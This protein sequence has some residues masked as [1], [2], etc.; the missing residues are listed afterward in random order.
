MKITFDSFAQSLEARFT[1][2]DNRFNQVFSD[3][4]KVDIVHS[5]DVSQDVLIVP[6]AALSIVDG[7][8]E[9]T[10]D[11][12]LLAPCSGSLRSTLGRPVEQ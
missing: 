3:A 11:R 2:V 5:S 6:L 12:S 1:S 9:S 4:S 7:R 8:S 10:P